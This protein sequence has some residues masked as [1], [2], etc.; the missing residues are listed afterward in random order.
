[1]PMALLFETPCT[2]FPS[3]HLLACSPLPLLAIPPLTSLLHL[4]RLVL[5][6][7]A[8]LV[9]FM[10]T[11]LLFSSLALLTLMMLSCLLSPSHLLLV[12]GGEKLFG[13]AKRLDEVD[14]IELPDIWE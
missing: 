3:A 8:V 13:V 7:F 5:L 12:F 2:Y 10:L 6:M 11:L 1:M 9:F 14:V 4:P